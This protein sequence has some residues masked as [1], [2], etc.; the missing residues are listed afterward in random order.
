MAEGTVNV[1]VSAIEGYA[2]AMREA[3]EVMV[4]EQ[5]RAFN[6]IA[7][8]DIK[9]FQATLPG[10]LHIRFKWLPKVFRY[11]ASDPRRAT[12]L[13]KLF[14]S[15]YTKWPA[16]A[17]FQ[18]GGTI[19][20]TSGRYL[21]VLTDAARGPDGRR[22]FSEAGLRDMIRSKRARLVPTPRGFLIVES[23]GGAARAAKGRTA[24]RETVLASLR[25]QVTERKRINFLELPEQRAAI[26]EEILE[27]AVENTAAEIAAR[28]AN[29]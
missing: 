17:A 27:S 9:A 8:G 16:A 19:K 10:Q 20:P 26:H 7:E 24:T 25:R 18:T 13:S 4:R 22:L 2:R 29:P 5:A 1:N 14:I 3:P 21:T 12:S 15:E 11:V 28:A 23:V 6:A